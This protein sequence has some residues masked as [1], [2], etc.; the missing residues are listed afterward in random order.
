MLT[1]L[2]QST[3]DVPVDPSL[4]WLDVSERV[5]YDVLRTSKRRDD[6]LLGRWTA[7]RLAQAVIAQER[8]E[9]RAL[10]EIVVTRA[11]DGAPY[12]RDYP[13]A[14]SISHSNGYAFCALCSDGTVGVDIE[15]IASRIPA[16]VGDY[17]TLAEI[18]AVEAASAAECDAWITAIWSA[19]EAVLKLLRI[20]LGV[21]MRA[22]S[23]VG[24]TLGCE[25][26][27]FIV[28]VNQA[29]LPDSLPMMGWW[30]V[31]GDFVLTLTSTWDHTPANSA[32][33][34]LQ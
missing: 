19:K 22:L 12:L 17:F 28:S 1:Y 18:T 29:Y 23:C 16:F 26:S 5:T 14:L 7:K 27:Q 3:D 9:A 25:W 6:W 10:H 8:G 13:H 21:D 24:D 15:R 33:V 34:Q 20:G 32:T 30:R 11:D 4:E 2:I 31:W